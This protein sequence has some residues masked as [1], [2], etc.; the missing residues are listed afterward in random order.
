ME[1]EVQGKFFAIHL[2]IA[3]SGDRVSITPECKVHD[4]A[5]TWL[6]AGSCP[7]V[8][9][10]SNPYVA[11]GMQQLGNVVIPISRVRV[12]ITLPHPCY[13]L[14]VRRERE[15]SQEPVWSKLSM[16]LPLSLQ[17]VSDFFFCQLPKNDTETYY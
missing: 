17:T 13:P 8:W 6:P 10:L 14:G 7:A 15:C 12:T 11:L 5:L 3:N 9:V 2:E 4:S 16:T 1:F